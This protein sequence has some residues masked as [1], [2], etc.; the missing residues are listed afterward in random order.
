[1]QSTRFVVV[2]GWFVCHRTNLTLIPEWLAVAVATQWP[3]SEVH[4]ISPRNTHQP[5]VF[6]CSELMAGMLHEA[7][8]QPGCLKEWRSEFRPQ[9]GSFAS[10]PKSGSESGPSIPKDL[11]QS[12]PLTTYKV[13]SRFGKAVTL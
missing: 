12:A 10:G 5:W 2:I 1:M 6:D 11:S 4:I 3:L 7:G 8:S 9:I 13:S